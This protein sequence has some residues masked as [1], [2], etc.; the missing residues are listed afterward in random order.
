M[1]DKGDT[2][3]ERVRANLVEMYETAAEKTDELA[4]V[5]VRKIDKISLSR[6]LEKRFSELGG[7]IYHLH[8]EGRVAEA[9][10]DPEVQ[11]LLEKVA[12]LERNL[13]EKEQEIE[14]IREEKRRKGEDRRSGTET[15]TESKGAAM[16][17][18]SA[19]G[20]AGTT[21]TGRPGSP[22]SGQATPGNS[23]GA[24]GGSPRS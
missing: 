1:A 15:M 2:L 22:P 9:G 11:D 24:E 17:G 23:E 14:T 18:E 5:G 4:K 16:G 21:A 8:T 10:S 6:H 13:E 20:A 3:W 12:G 19:A 7:R